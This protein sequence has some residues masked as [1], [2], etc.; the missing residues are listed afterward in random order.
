MR[1]A[2]DIAEQFVV[3]L[4]AADPVLATY[5]G[6]LGHEHELPDY[7]PDGYA[8]RED[9]LRRARAAMAGATPSDD[10]ERV[11]QSSFLERA[12][13]GLAQDEAHTP[14]SR[15][16]VI[17]SAAHEIRGVFDLMATETEEDWSA[18]STRLG[19]VPQALA[20][21][22]ATL[23][24]EAGHGHVS[25][26]RQMVEAAKQIHGWTG[27]S[28]SGGDVFA[29]LVARA[30]DVPASLETDLARNAVL[31]STAYEDFATFLEQ[32]LAR[33]AGR[34]RPS[35][36]STTPSPRATSS[37]P[38]STSTRPTP[39]ASRSCPPRD[40]DARGLGAD[41]R[42]RRHDRRRG[43]GARRRPGKGASR[44]RRRSATGCRSWPTA[45]AELHGTHF[46]IPEP[47]RRIECCLA[48]TRTAASTTPARA[49]TSP[50]PGRDVVGGAAGDDDV[51]TPGAR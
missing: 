8:A 19:A 24:H 22:R 1:E 33:G 47:V 16:S 10:R 6:I 25:P 43:R 48:P 34:R 13:V 18:V 41:R 30:G 38:R 46:D 51:L 3:D 15:I 32:E 49:R 4:A 35:G 2:D 39:G 20:D 12:D 44:A 27:R 17:E 45:V 31:A 5:C 36:G 14:Q 26:R 23:L 28:G 11:A 7:T 50:A 21:Y 42:R 9:L 29:Q 40:R 37:A